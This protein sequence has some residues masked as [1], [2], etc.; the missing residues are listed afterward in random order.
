MTLEIYW[1]AWIKENQVS[2]GDVVILPQVTQSIQNA[3][4][5]QRTKLE[6][7]LLQLQD[8]K[9][10]LE[11]EFELIKDFTRQEIDKTYQQTNELAQ[12]A[13]WE[14]IFRNEKKFRSEADNLLAY[15]KIISE[16]EDNIKE[17]IKKLDLNPEGIL[18]ILS[19]NFS[20]N[21]NYRSKQHWDRN[22]WMPKE[23]KRFPL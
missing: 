21:K 20:T 1:A 7:L 15:F 22:F 18:H 12:L 19:F 17:S 5:F 9:I 4:S 8:L 2:N 13:K 11:Y 10:N 23:P 16:A 3:I 6:Q 14:W